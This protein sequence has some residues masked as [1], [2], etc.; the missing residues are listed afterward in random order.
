[1]GHKNNTAAWVEELGSTSTYRRSERTSEG[2]GAP[3][4]AR[5]AKSELLL[6]VNNLWYVRVLEIRMYIDNDD[7]VEPEEKGIFILGYKNKG[8]IV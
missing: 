5:A 7:L 3:K 1:M 4:P 6:D 2:V 8:L